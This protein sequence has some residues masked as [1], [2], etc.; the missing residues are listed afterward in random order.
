MI[1]LMNASKALIS[2]MDTICRTKNIAFYAAHTFGL[3]GIV[4]A[5]L[6]QHTFRRC[7]YV[8]DGASVRL[9]L[10]KF[11]VRQRRKIKWLNPNNETFHRLKTRC[12]WNGI[13]CTVPSDA[14]LNYRQCSCTGPFCWN[15]MR[16]MSDFRA[17]KIRTRSWRWPRECAKNMKYRRICSM[18][19]VWTIWQASQRSIWLP[20][21][22]SWAEWSVRKS[23]KPFRRKMSRFVISFSTTPFKAMVACVELEISRHSGWL[24]IRRVMTLHF[25]WVCSR[26]K[27]ASC[28]TAKHGWR[29][30]TWNAIACFQSL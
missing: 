25:S 2:K 12:E 10:V 29:T 17:S 14:D 7:V 9:T 11:V 19:H 27:I 6:K 21:V 20:F 23:S 28:E 24:R 5:D 16:C 18:K 22:P 26:Y 30:G 15:F 1:I 8:I 3:D 13:R 4:F